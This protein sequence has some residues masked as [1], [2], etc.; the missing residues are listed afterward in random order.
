MS[1]HGPIFLGLAS[2]PFKL[3]V[4]FRAGE[5][6]PG[7]FRLQGDAMEMKQEALS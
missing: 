4:R 6:K 5:G 2:N 7:V 3:M 1:R